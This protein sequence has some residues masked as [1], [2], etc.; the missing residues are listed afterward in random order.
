MSKSCWYV[1]VGVGVGV[2]MVGWFGLGGGRYIA[3]GFLLRWACSWSERARRW[4]GRHLAV[5]GLPGGNVF[6]LSRGIV[7]SG[8]IHEYI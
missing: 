2:G 7:V 5:V 4:S 3:V 6:S 8:W 1:D